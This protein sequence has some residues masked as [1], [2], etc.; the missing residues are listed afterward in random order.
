MGLESHS[1]GCVVDTKLSDE[2]PKI[3]RVLTT[4]TPASRGLQVPQ[5]AHKVWLIAHRHPPSS[6]LSSFTGCQ[7]P[8]HCGHRRGCQQGSAEFPHPPCCRRRSLLGP[9][10]LPCIFQTQMR[11]P[12]DRTAALCSRA[13]RHTP[14]REEA[15]LLIQP[16]SQPRRCLQWQLPQR[17]WGRVEVCFCGQ[18][19]S[20][21]GHP[22]LTAAQRSPG[23]WQSLLGNRRPSGSPTQPGSNN[24]PSR[25]PPANVVSNFDDASSET[26]P[27]HG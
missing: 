26:E 5:K 13:C 2:S 15:A 6:H 20:C 21:K 8:W 19:S 16:G 27:S 18:S 4:R 1:V 7:R 25:H 3:H 14:A 12:T 11:G 24:K 9:C 10:L 22:W 23:L 17:P